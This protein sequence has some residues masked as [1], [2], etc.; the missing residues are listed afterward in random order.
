MQDDDDFN[1]DTNEEFDAEEDDDTFP[2]NDREVELEME[3]AFSDVPHNE[4]LSRFL[5]DPWPRLTLLLTIIGLL[6][7]ILVPHEIWHTEVLSGV[8]A[9]HLFVGTYLILILATGA[10]VLALMVWNTQKGWLRYGGLTN[11]VVILLCVAIGTADTIAWS[12]TKQ[13]LFPSIFEAPLLSFMAIVIMLCIYSLWMIRK[14]P[15]D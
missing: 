10:T 11:V 8:V 2:D 5:V 3:A 4:M 13:G 7:V 15:T 1:D 6:I 12:F 14:T 9:G